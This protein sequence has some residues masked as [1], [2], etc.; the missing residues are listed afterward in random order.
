MSTRFI[1]LF[2]EVIK[3][4][5]CCWVR[6]KNT[7][8]TR[9]MG[10]DNA[11]RH[12]MVQVIV[13]G[14]HPRVRKHMSRVPVC[15]MCA[16]MIIRW[17]NFDVLP[18]TCSF[19]EFMQWIR[20]DDSPAMF[21]RFPLIYRVKAKYVNRPGFDYQHDEYFCIGVLHGS[22]KTLLR[23]VGSIQEEAVEYQSSWGIRLY[24]EFDPYTIAVALQDIGYVLSVERRCVDSRM[25]TLP[26]DIVREICK[27]VLIDLY[28]DKKAA[29]DVWREYHTS[30]LQ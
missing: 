20:F 25:R 16:P 19:W 29:L 18:P 14:A 1:E 3:Y 23:V 28:D 9:C 10:C 5:V 22:I 17:T 24:D 4:A 21:I 13:P 2:P 30:A 27:H 26:L 8:P 6:P 12:P 15:I 7:K 11:H